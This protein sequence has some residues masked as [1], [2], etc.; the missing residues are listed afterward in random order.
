MYIL[1]VMYILNL[2]LAANYYLHISAIRLKP[3]TG[4]LSNT[5][6]FVLLQ[7]SAGKI[8]AFTRMLL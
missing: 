3:P 7:Y 2:R 6:H 8:L 5:A 4:R 1:K